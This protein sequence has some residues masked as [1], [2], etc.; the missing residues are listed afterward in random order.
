MDKAKRVVEDFTSRA[1]HH[2]TTVT[3]NV[4]PA[5]EHETIRPTQHEEIN[6]AINKEIHQDHYHRKVQPV[7][8][9]Q[10]LPEQHMHKQGKVINREFDNRD[11]ASTERA[12]RAEAGKLRDERTVTGTTHTQS[13]APVVQGEQVHHHVHETVQPVVHKE[14][15][16]PSV[17]HTT[18]P[19]HETHHEQAKIHGTT[20]L[21][22]VS[23]DEFKRQGGALGGQSSRTGT[24]EGCPKG[25]HMAGCGHA[26]GSG[27][28]PSM[29]TTSS[30]TRGM[31]SRSSSISSSDEEKMSSNRISG[32]KTSSTTTS[33][34]GLQSSSSA[35]ST[36]KKKP[37]L[38][39]R[40]NPMKDSDGDGKRGFMS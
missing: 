39:D 32:T 9:T 18:V 35:T 16:Q 4:A 30:G 7:H 24:F 37:S 1:G 27:P 20:T 8:D 10:V 28:Q 36:E 33:G 11:D 2:D 6:T 38:I 34:I 25:V 3:E 22:A 15:I 23:M 31:R 17:V 40:L 14:T 19:I 13:H 29:S 12:L 26:D 5:V 21:P